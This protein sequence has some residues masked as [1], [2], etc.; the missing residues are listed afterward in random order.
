MYPLLKRHRYPRCRL[1]ELRLFPRVVPPS[2]IV[3]K[4]CETR[5]RMEDNPKYVVVSS[6]RSSF[7]EEIASTRA[8]HSSP[9]PPGTVDQGRK[10]RMK[11]S[12]WQENVILS[13]FSNTKTL[14]T[15]HVLRRHLHGRIKSGWWASAVC[16]IQTFQ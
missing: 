10:S 1:I 16:A 5:K 9:A 14:M 11:T 12:I 4:I 6:C 7:N 13:F 8:R 2:V 15:F 3:T